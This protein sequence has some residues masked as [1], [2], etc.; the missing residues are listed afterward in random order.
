MAGEAFVRMLAFPQLQPGEF[1]SQMVCRPLSD[2]SPVCGR[3]AF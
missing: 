2:G 1:I 3:A